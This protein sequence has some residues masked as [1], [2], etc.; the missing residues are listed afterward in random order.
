[1]P[2]VPV[3]LILHIALALGLLLPSILLPFA[4]RAQ[5]PA[6]E[7]GSPVVRGL[8]VLQAQG[9]VAIAA[10]LAVTGIGLVAAVGTS[11]LAQPWLLVAVGIYAANLLL[12]LFIQRPN[13]RRLLNVRAAWDDRVWQARARRQRYISYVMAGLTSTIGLLMSA[14]PNLW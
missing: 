2:L 3:L 11:L 1:M 8:L 13:L 9:A 10:G 7:S 6:A 14:K 5:R 12:A 4:L